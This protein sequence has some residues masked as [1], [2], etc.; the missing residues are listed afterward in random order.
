MLHPVRH[1]R[2][3]P[4]KI[5]RQQHANHAVQLVHRA[6]GLDAGAFLGCAGTVAQAGFARIAGAGIDPGETVA[7]WVVAVNLKNSQPRMNT[8]LRR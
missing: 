6:D 7:H 5:F 4:G 2:A 3:S 1:C 8:N